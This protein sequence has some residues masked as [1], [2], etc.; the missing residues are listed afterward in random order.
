M[1]RFGPDTCT[2]VDQ[3]SEREWLETNGLGGFAS[4]TIINLNTRR[5]HGLLMAAT[6][7]PGGR[8][9]LLAKLE[10]TLV[11]GDRR[12]ELAVNRHPGVI[13]PHG[14]EYLK[15]FRLDPFPIFTYEVAGAQVEK[16]VFMLYGENTTIVEYKL[17]GDGP[18]CVLEVR[19]LIAFRDFH[20]LTHANGAINSTVETRPGAASVTPYPGLPALHF[21]HDAEE[22]NETGEWYYFFEYDAERERGLDYQEDLFNPFAMHFHFSGRETG[23]IIASTELHNVAEGPEFRRS[24]IESRSRTVAEVLTGNALAE[25]LELVSGQ[26][27]VKS[28]ERKSIIAGYHWF[29]VWGRDAMIS[30]PGL[31]LVTGRWDIARDILLEFARTINQ[32][33]LPNRFPEGDEPAEY[34]TVDGSLWFFEAIRALAQHTA[35]YTFVQNQIYPALRDIIDWYVRGT[36]YGIQVDARD[37]ML[38]CGEP[39]VQLTWMD[40]KVGDWVMTPR[41]GKPV[42]VQALWYNALRI[43]EDFAHRFGDGAAETQAATLAKQSRAAFTSSFWNQEAGCLYDVISTDLINT[44]LIN[45]AERDAS[46]RPNQILAVSLGHSML[47]EE[48]ARQIMDVVERQLLTPYGLRTL[49]PHD[50]RY[51]SRYEGDIGSRDSAYHQGT[52]WPWL[53]GPFITAYFKVNGRTEDVRQRVQQWLN[54]FRDHLGNAGLGQ[55]SEI[56]DGDPPHKPRGC[57]AQAWSVAELL[58]VVVE[59]HLL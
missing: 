44:D 19:P 31:T 53:M 21:A 43:M 37:G 49:S 11:I 38:R 46:I 36:R 30:L 5:Y 14:H 52:V 16:R 59:E 2:N 47:S 29:G 58:R 56:F 8:L 33:M 39:G 10:E 57:I 15:E 12:Y 7:P 54:P 6:K 34:N 13:H 41:T 35:D 40:A 4:S 45:N 22:L 9:L 28:N 32:G 17:G 23:T 24:E 1:I 48:H 25:A 26:F 42:E 55:I 20:D 27:L 3:A 18:E 51:R 50:P